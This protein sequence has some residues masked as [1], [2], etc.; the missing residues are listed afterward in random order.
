MTDKH[1]IF[2]TLE[3]NK[4]DKVIEEIEDESENETSENET[5]SDRITIA[6]NLGLKRK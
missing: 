6:Y 3:W 2:Q 1:L 4:F 5:D